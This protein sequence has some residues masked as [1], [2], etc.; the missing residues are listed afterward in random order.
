MF[1]IIPA[2]IKSFYIT[3]DSRQ[4]KGRPYSYLILGQTLQKEKKNK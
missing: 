3:G 4:S 1:M 2:G